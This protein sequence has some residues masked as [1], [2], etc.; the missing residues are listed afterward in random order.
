MAFKKHMK[1]TRT[2]PLFGYLLILPSFLFLALFTYLPIIRSAWMSLF[3]NRGE[4]VF[5]QNYARMFSTPTFL[6]VIKNNVWYTIGS[7][8]PAVS[9]GLFLAILINKPLRFRGFF[10]LSYFYPTIIPMSAV[11]MV[12]VFLFN[13]NYG[14]VNQILDKLGFA[15]RID[16]LNISPHALIAITI[17]AVWKYAGYYMLLFLAG[18]Q[19]I[20]DDL[21]E[22]ARI[23]GASWWQTFRYITFP[24]LTPTTFFVALIAIINSFQSVDQVYVMTRGGPYNTSNVL[25]YYIYQH[26]FVYW[27]LGY[28]SAASTLLFGFLLIGTIIYFVSLERRIQ[29][30]R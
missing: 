12:W 27:D 20:G 17:V 11:S 9:I 24:L 30:E 10:R 1:S 15:S 14:A 5:F 19:S 21:Y 2:S 7:V 29:Y 22:A 25:L 28:A 16:W 13:R 26:G 18:L 23:E 8:L 3:N 4:F 6:Q